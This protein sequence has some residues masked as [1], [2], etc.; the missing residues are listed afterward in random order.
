MGRLETVENSAA[1]SGR[2][3]RSGARVPISQ[4][5]LVRLFLSA[6]GMR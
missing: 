2:S 6:G 5:F 4:S 3:L 1:R